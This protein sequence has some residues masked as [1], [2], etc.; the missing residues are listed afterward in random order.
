[1][2]SGRGPI[3]TRSHTDFC[4]DRTNPPTT[5]PECREYRSQLLGE[6]SSHVEKVRLLE[7]KSSDSAA[8]EEWFDQV[9]EV[10]ERMD[11][12]HRMTMSL[13]SKLSELGLYVLLSLTIKRSSRT[14][15][16]PLF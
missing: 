13:P 12:I 2:G 8:V 15:G 4:L 1:M 5:V 3:S 14:R 10:M 16:T 9:S 7:L 6:I 11:G